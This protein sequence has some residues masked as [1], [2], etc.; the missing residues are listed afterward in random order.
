MLR[1]A[2]LRCARATHARAAARC[3]WSRRGAMR[4]VMQRAQRCELRGRHA[5]VA[6]RASSCRAYR[7]ASHA[8]SRR[9]RCRRARGPHSAGP[10]R[11]EA[12]QS[13]RG[14]A[15]GSM[16]AAGGADGSRRGL[17]MRRG[18]ERAQHPRCNRGGAMR[19]REQRE[20]GQA[21]MPARAVVRRVDQTRSLPSCRRKH[22]RRRLRVGAGGAAAPDAA[23][24]AVAC[25]KRSRRGHAVGP[26]ARTR[27]SARRHGR[28]RRTV[29]ARSAVAAAWRFRCCGL[30]RRGRRRR[31]AT[32]VRL[33]EGAADT[34]GRRR[35]RHAGRRGRHRR[36]YSRGA[37][38]V[39][40][41]V[42]CS[43]AAC[44][45][46]A[47]AAALP[48]RHQAVL[49]RVSKACLSGCRPV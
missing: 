36:R 37:T 20:E 35:G 3:P 15:R 21:R 47:A 6:P 5:R 43:G 19:A 34:V 27:R 14:Q 18:A 2:A 38:R 9:R 30:G 49:L 4:R 13:G 31:P 17:A 29:V 46:C 33:A 22:G 24:R 10:W 45:P 7:G 40:H 25:I 28:A 32:A 48:A 39:R 26:R 41:S 16:P 1:H 8:P 11:A 42:S 44:A 12:A 23:W